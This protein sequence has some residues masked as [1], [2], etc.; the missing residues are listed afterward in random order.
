MNFA[1]ER[2]KKDGPMIKNN[3]HFLLQ[4]LEFPGEFLRKCKVTQPSKESL[5]VHAMDH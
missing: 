1:R 2:I 4:Q 3:T 5:G